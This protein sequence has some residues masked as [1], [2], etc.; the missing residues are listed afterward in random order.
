MLKGNLSTRPFYNERLVS[1]ILLVATLA[2]IALT[3]FNA[4]TIYRLSDERKKQR[5]DLNRVAADADKSR[6]SASSLEA[7]LDKSNLLML[8]GATG[9]ANDLIDQRMFS[10]TDFF[11][12]VEK[13]LPLDARL[14][15]VAP[16][17]ER[18]V[19]MIQMMLNVKRQEDL[20]T[21]MDALLA[22]GTFHDLLPGG[23][24]RN[25]DG[26][27]TYT[28]I[29]GYVPPVGV[30]GRVKTPVRRGERP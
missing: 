27:L 6:A 20:E 26:T 15:A 18:G 5:A 16:R 10:W 1:V 11:A 30:S 28:L 9:E 13:T 23:A 21:F 22:T 3:I 4:T 17:V 25:D 12:T 19:F 14:T 8:A 24:Q 29:G 2:G 7:T